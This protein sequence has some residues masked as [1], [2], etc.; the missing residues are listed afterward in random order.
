MEELY[1][2]YGY[3][4]DG[5]DELV[6]PGEKGMHE[7]A[8]I[9][10]KLRKENV[11]HAFSSEVVAF[12]DYQKQ[13]R[14]EFPS[15]EIPVTDVPVSDVV[16]FD[17]ANGCRILARP[18][19][20]EPKLKIYYTGVGATEEEAEQAMSRMKKEITEVINNA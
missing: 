14:T 3:Y 2:E 17:L 4:L 11:L 10:A 6:R 13:L 19:G 18:S 5:L 12:T 7:I 1:E 16:Q 20:T 15:V 8:E 9:M